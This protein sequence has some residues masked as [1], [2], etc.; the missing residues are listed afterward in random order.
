MKLLLCNACRTSWIFAYMATFEW[1]LH[2]W[3]LSAALSLRCLRA[4][5]ISVECRSVSEPGKRQC[6]EML[7]FTRNQKTSRGCFSFCGGYHGI[8]W[9][10]ANDCGHLRIVLRG[11]A[12]RSSTER[13]I[14][15]PVLI[16][17]SQIVL[18][19]IATSPATR[20]AFK[21]HSPCYPAK[22]YIL[23]LS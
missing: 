6:R 10:L 14:Q 21:I 7:T 2:L 12:T 18:R 19:V 1:F 20:P 8:E 5:L 15:F 9:R 17:L 3:L 16:K 13:I 11:K 4:G 23:V 22:S